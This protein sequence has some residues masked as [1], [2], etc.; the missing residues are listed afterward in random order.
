MAHILA[1]SA[2]KLPFYIECVDK[3]DDVVCN[4]MLAALPL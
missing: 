2:K 1:F 3:G 4:S